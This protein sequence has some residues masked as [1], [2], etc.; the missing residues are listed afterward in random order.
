M[1][2]KYLFVSFSL[3]FYQIKRFSFRYW[4]SFISVFFIINLFVLNPLKADSIESDSPRLSK[5]AQVSILTC[6]PGPELYEAFGHSAIRIKD[7][8]N[9]LDL[10]FNY[11][12]F[13]FNQEN[14]YGN[15]AKGSMLYMLGLSSMD[16]FMNQYRYYKRSVREQVLNLDSVEIQKLVSFLNTNLRPENR[17]Y[18]YDY[19]Y[20]NCS[21]KIVDLL[22]SALNQSILWSSIQP[23]G[24][25]THRKLIHQYTVFQPWGRLGID[26]GLGLPIDQP[27]IGKEFR[28]L[29]DGIEQ[30]L[31]RAKI[32]RGFLEFPMVISSSV[33]Y[34]S[35]ASF[36]SDT[37]LISPAFIFSVLLFISIFLFIKQNRLA[38]LF[39][40]WNG[41]LFS[42]AGI[43]GL[44][45]TLIWFFTNHKTAAWNFNLIWANP[46]FLVLGFYLMVSAQKPEW[47]R[48]LLFYYFGIVLAIWFVLPQELNV[49]LLPFVAGLWVL[50][51]PYEKDSLS[52]ISK[53]IL[54][55]PL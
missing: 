24:K 20:N 41:I 36:G 1:K 17:E 22:D 16:E 14:F 49:N 15:F 38:R 34:Q 55:D 9:G 3:R 43:L 47:L 44:I 37:F 45:E 8:I 26:L 35:D 21:T 42:L 18:H 31:S 6:G 12:V 7:P 52:K 32:K 11:G 5:E 29:P 46:A 19:F 54:T 39:R 2:V 28:F 23:Q 48:V 4:P 25:I 10:V 13:D 27:M 40:I 33:L 50:Q 51:F 53:P 30:E